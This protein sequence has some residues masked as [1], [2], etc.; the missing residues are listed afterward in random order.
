MY[1]PIKRC[2]TKAT[3][4]NPSHIENEFGALLGLQGTEKKT[5]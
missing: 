2:T 5:L 3:Q 1:T 4:S